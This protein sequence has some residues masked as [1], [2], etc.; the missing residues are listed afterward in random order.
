MASSAPLPPNGRLRYSAAPVFERADL[1]AGVI[2]QL[3][4]GDAFSVV[5]SDGKFYQV[6]LANGAMGFVYGNNVSG[7]DLPPAPP[8]T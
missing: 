2:T 7:T 6:R 3:Y 8:P 1:A 4:R 5:G